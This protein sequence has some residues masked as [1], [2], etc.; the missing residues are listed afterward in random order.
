MC[1]IG[2]EGRTTSARSAKGW[3]NY[4]NRRQGSGRCGPELEP[5]GL[6]ECTVEPS[7]DQCHHAEHER[8]SE[9]PPQLGHVLEVHAVDAGDRSRYGRDRDP[10]GNA[11]HVVVLAH[12]DL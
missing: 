4:G 1:K 7:A 12:R 2:E 6:A 10:R 8:V 5:A 3:V 11:A 9:G